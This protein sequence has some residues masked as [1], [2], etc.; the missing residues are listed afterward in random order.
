[1]TQTE[2][3]RFLIDYETDFISLGKNFGLEELECADLYR[4]K[5]ELLREQLNQSM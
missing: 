3:M 1:M 4:Q 5:K 2:K